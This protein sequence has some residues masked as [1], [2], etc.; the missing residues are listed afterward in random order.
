MRILGIDPSTYTG[1]VFLDNQ[2]SEKE[3]CR[4]VNFPNSKGFGRLQLIA[5]GVGSLLEQYPP[6]K[7]YIEGY[8]FGNHT[9]LV[10]LV[11]IG[12]IIRAELFNRKI[13]WEDVPPT[14]LKKWTTQKG[15]ATKAL[16][17]EVVKARWG[18][19]SSSDDVIDAYALAR[20]GLNANGVPQ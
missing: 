20:Y 10:T 2:P 16:M 14:A 19:T 9:S 11:E 4:L 8:A 13:Q 6:D 5:Q 17:A 1:M 15:N 18:F 3:I 12:T 7:V